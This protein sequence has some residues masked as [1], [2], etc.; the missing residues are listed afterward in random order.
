MNN[1]ENNI[2]QVV[3]IQLCMIEDSVKFNAYNESTIMQI[4]KI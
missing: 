3:D 1:I 2:G 4:C